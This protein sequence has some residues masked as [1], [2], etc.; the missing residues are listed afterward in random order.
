VA[1]KHEMDI[2]VVL[3][4]NDELGK[5]S[6]EQRDG[7]WKLWQTALQ[8]P[9]SGEYA[10]L[11]GGS[12]TTVRSKDELTAAFKTGLNSKKPHS[13]EIMSDAILT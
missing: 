1:I 7:E 12:G 11:C 3:L 9:F 5:I 8:N 4:H 6:K 2:T 10:R 13:V